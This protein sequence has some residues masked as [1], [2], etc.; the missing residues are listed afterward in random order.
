MKFSQQVHF[1]QVF[2]KGP[3]KSHHSQWPPLDWS[4]HCY[5][6]DK[7]SALPPPTCI[8]ILKALQDL[9]SLLTITNCQ[10]KIALPSTAAFA[11]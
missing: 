2:V 4:S 9:M 1:W 10:L 11:E 5:D 6:D 8:E 7:V 3:T